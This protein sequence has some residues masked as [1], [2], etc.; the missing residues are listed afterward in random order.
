MGVRATRCALPGCAADV[1]Q[2]GDG[3]VRRYCS[4]AHEQPVIDDMPSK[5]LQRPT[6]GWRG[7]IY[8]A[9]GGLLNPGVREDEAAHDALLNRIRRPLRGGLEIAVTSMKGGVGKTTVTACLGLT[10][11]EHRGDRVITLDANP[12]AG[13]LADRLTGEV[14]VTMRQMLDNIEDIRSLTDVS[15]YTSEAGRLHVIASEQDPAISEAFNRAEYERICAVL[16]RYYDILITD[17]GT[18]M[19]HSA[20]EGTLARAGALIVVGTPTVDGASRASKTL[21]WLDAHGYAQLTAEAVVVLS[22]DRA[23]ERIDRERIRAH[24]DNR[25]R[26]VVEIPYD[27]HLGVGGR[28]DPEAL[29]A[30]VREAFLT[31]GALLVDAY[32]GPPPVQDSDWNRPSAPPRGLPAVPSRPPRRRSTIPKGRILVTAVT[33][34]ALLIGVVAGIAVITAPGTAPTPRV[35]AA[36][37]PPAEATPPPPAQPAAPPPAVP[38]PAKPAPPAQAEMEAAPS[39]P[40][41][42]LGTPIPVGTTPGFVAVAPNGRLAYVANRDAK[43]ISVVDTS[44]N[45]VT[46]TIPVDAGPPHFLTFSPDGRRVYVS[47]FNQERTIRSVGVLD[48]ITNKIIANV[49]VRTRPYVAA[50]T[51]DGRRLYV[52]NHDS[53]TVSVLDTASNTIIKEIKVAP[54]PHCIEFSRDG[55]RAY[56]ANHE[57]NLIS[58]LDTSTDT[59]I[60]EIRVQTSPHSV[61]VHPTLP[62]VA[63]VNYDA[64][65]VSM[66]DTTANRVIA[67]VP[68]G[69]NPQ[70]ITW[71]PD[72]RFAYV[73][74]VGD[75]TLSVIDNDT[76]RVTATIPTGQ[77]PTSVAVLPNGRTGYVTN[78]DSGTMSTV[79][80]GG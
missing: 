64:N 40:V 29:R 16:T 79:H 66:I 73:A 51:P 30:P 62:L 71:A 38:P 37:P 67:T 8:V 17:S 11:A 5:P 60:A 78:L 57:S 1:E 4:A 63:N 33:V 42:S 14:G 56:T 25:C 3:S 44:I 65:S 27:P 68:V 12:D 53:G 15:R 76:K 32:G 31:L 61:A 54:N 10:L 47:I 74:N 75:G 22:C 9:S 55:T 43:I 46:A 36:A 41:P 23:S 19:V 58:V 24:F 48:T 7:A 35:T 6:T 49:P 59:V 77:S 45:R 21:D 18:G 20:M 72:G 69:K 13:T 34:F 80:L 50:L 52:P 26:A 2:I 28:I 39:V 70:D